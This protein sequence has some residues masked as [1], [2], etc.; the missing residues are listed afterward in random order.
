[1]YF[2][3]RNYNPIIKR[4]FKS[5]NIVVNEDMFALS[6]MIQWVFRSRIRKNQNIYLYCPSKR[7]RTLF[8]NWLNNELP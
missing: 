5:K 7:M 4:W 2:V 3:S 1:M 8:T 6:E